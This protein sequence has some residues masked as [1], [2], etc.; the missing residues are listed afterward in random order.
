MS[1]DLE[2]AQ[3]HV[4]LLGWEDRIAAAKARYK[5]INDA[6]KQRA[7][8]YRE[9]ADMIG[10][11]P[12]ALSAAEV[13]HLMDVSRQTVYTWIERGHGARLGAQS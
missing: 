1:T 3:A 2:Q 12:E 6:E 13:A 8:L 10:N 4:R 11:S 5:A 9:V 7:T